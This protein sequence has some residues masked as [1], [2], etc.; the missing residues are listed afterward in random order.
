MARAE[1]EPVAAELLARYAHGALSEAEQRALYEAALAD[2]AV[3]ETL[4]E[5]QALR[6][7]L[8]DPA[9]RAQALQHLRAR[10]GPR[11]LAR[12][13]AI[14]AALALIAVSAWLLYRPPGGPDLLAVAAAPGPEAAL[15]WT[16]ADSA[17]QAKSLSAVDARLAVRFPSGSGR[18]HPGDPIEV[19]ITVDSE[20]WVALLIDPPSGGPRLLLP[21]G[22]PGTVRIA[23]GAPVR[24]GSERS[25]PLRAPATPGRY[26]LRLVAVGLQGRS[27]PLDLDALRE[28]L[29]VGEATLAQA[30]FELA[31]DR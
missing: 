23:P 5:E 21:A 19:S 26:R 14:A 3:F 12:W 7:L 15:L 28:R 6:E 13:G 29:S 25:Q 1:D 20:A 16:E 10:A 8:A 11:S 24:L 22:P 31:G 18:P 2:Q 9:V 4:L 17:P 27:A 30:S